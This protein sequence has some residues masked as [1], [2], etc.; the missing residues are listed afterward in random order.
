MDF[1][2]LGFRSDFSIFGVKKRLFFI[3]IVYFRYIK[4]ARK[5]FAFSGQYFGKLIF[6]IFFS[7]NLF[8]E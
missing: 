7:E 8:S 1:L 5:F 4:L 6:R 3:K 2:K